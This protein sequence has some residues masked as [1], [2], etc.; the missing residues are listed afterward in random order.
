[1]SQGVGSNDLGLDRGQ[2]G[3]PGIVVYFKKVGNKLLLIQ[4]NLGYRAITSNRLEKQS[5][6]EAFAKSVLHGFFIDD[7]KKGVYLVD[8]TS[9]FMRDAHGVARSLAR[10]GQGNYNLDKII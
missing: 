4:P 1:M 2:I 9:F 3:T 7:E 8:A 10:Q 6:E 5:V